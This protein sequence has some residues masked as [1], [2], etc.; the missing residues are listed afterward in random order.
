[1]HLFRSGGIPELVKMLSVSINAVRH[2]AITTLH[3]LLL[4][5]DSAKQVAFI[6]IN[7]SKDTLITFYAFYFYF[8]LFFPLEFV[9][10]LNLRKHET[11]VDLRP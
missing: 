10:I 4:Y 2:Y 1:M 3:N 8:L 7:I 6:R 9:N 5:M 11:L